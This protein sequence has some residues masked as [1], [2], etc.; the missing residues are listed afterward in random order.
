MMARMLLMLACLFDRSCAFRMSKLL[1]NVDSGFVR[2][3]ELK[4]ARVALLAVPTLGIMSSMGIEEPVKWL[5]TQPLDTQ[6]GFFS[7]AALVESASLARLGPNFSL[8]DGLVP[9]NFFNDK[10]VTVDLE[11][12][13]GRVAMLAAAGILASGAAY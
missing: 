1:S 11:L 6:L 13:S 2:E 12:M 7:T 4:H 5:S 3:A 9:G 8:K 10:N